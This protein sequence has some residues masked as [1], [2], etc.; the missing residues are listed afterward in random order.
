P[1]AILAALEGR[2]I[3][4]YGQGRNIR[5][6]LFVDDHVSALFRILEKGRAGET[7]VVGGRTERRNIDLVKAI[8]TLLDDLVPASPFRPHS[9]L[10]TLVPDRPGHDERYAID[11]SKIEGELGWR[12]SVSVEDGLRRTVAWY[13][14]N[15][16]WWQAIRDRGFKGERMGLPSSG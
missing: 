10:M 16:W 2:P 11:P 4:I 3:P 9:R 7:Y 14:E 12:A 6:W 5:D 8:C 13:L 1:L 15:R